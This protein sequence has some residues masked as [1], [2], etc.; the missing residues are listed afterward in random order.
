MIRR[1][2]YFWN[3]N[4]KR[5]MLRVHLQVDKLQ[6]SFRSNA[7]EL[8]ESKSFA[9]LRAFKTEL[10]LEKSRHCAVCKGTF[11]FSLA[12][13]ICMCL[14]IHAP[15]RSKSV[16]ETIFCTSQ[17]WKIQAWNHRWKMGISKELKEEILTIIQ[18]MT[19]SRSEE[20]YM[21]LYEK[22][23]QIAPEKFMRYYNPNWHQIREEWVSCH[24]KRGNLMNDT[25]NR[26]EG[27]NSSLK[28]VRDLSN[29]NLN[30]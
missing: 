30:H 26:T 6:M 3:V 11:W 22:L 5:L 4:N 25:N 20:E 15:P 17:A 10:W 9:L 19:Y 12:A 8:V 18:K 16:R 28:R 27:L 7:S 13:V 23:C 2:D 1:Q 29:I 24:M 21:E 14:V